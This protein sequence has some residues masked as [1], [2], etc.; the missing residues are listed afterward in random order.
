[1]GKNMVSVRYLERIKI[2]CERNREYKAYEDMPK[3]VKIK[4][5]F[6]NDTRHART[7]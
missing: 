7:I 2:L 6:K 1:M 4:E 3:N 5:K